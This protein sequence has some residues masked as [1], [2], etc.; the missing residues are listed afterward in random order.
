[1]L[2]TLTVDEQIRHFAEAEFVIAPHGAGLANLLFCQPSTVL[3]ELMPSHYVNWAMRRIAAVRG[4]R[5]GCLVGQSE[6]VTHPV[7]PHDTGWTV[8]LDDITSL[9][10]ADTPPG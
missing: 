5:Y 9:L 6:P 7:W 3:V 4:I 1:M 8:R 2:E 10:A